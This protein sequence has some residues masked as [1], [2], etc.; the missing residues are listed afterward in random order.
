MRDVGTNA[1]VLKLSIK[2]R[3]VLL[4]IKKEKK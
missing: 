2:T 4:E 1:I 3:K